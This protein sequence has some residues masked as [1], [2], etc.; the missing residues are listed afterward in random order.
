M[1]NISA[2]DISKPVSTCPNTGI[3]Y[4]AVTATPVTG[5][6]WRLCKVPAGIRVTSVVLVNADLGTSAPADIGFGHVDGTVG[7]VDAFGAAQELGTA[8]TTVDY[9]GDA[10]VAIAKDS[11]I[12]LTFGTINTGNSGKVSVIVT[13][14][15]FGAK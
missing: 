5:D 1:A 14:E 2:T 8:A 13:G 12:T 6:V 4:G 9:L 10:P 7:D 15:L 11:F 3:Y